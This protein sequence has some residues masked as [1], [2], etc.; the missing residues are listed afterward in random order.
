MQCRPYL[1]LSMKFD[2]T[3]FSDVRTTISASDSFLRP[4]TEMV[5]SALEPMLNL[6]QKKGQW[7][8]VSA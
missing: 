1:E 8:R 6:L 4:N 5:P 3:S 7:S 2:P